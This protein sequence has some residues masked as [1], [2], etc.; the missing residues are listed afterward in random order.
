MAKKSTI[1]LNKEIQILPSTKF[2]DL[3]ENEIKRLKNRLDDCVL[4]LLY[5]NTNPIP[6]SLAHILTNTP[7]SLSNNDTSYTNGRVIKISYLHMYLPVKMVSFIILHEA[8]HVLFMHIVRG[9]LLHHKRFNYACDYWINH[10]LTLFMNNKS[11]NGDSIIEVPQYIRNGLPVSMLYDTKYSSTSLSEEQIYEM[12]KDDKKFNNID[13]GD[14]EFGGFDE[15]DYDID[16]DDYNKISGKIEQIKNHLKQ[17]GNGKGN[18]LC[19]IDRL[20]ANIKTTSSMWYKELDYIV[21]T[22]FNKQIRYD[23]QREHRR[24]KSEF[25]LPNRLTNKKNK[26]SLLVVFDTS[27]SISDDNLSLFVGE[28]SKFVDNTDIT[29][30]SVDTDVHNVVKCETT[31]DLKK[32]IPK[33]GGGTDFNPAFEFM[34][35]HN[36]DAIIYFTDGFGD[37]DVYK[38]IKL[39]NKVFW[40][41]ISSSYPDFIDGFGRAIV[42]EDDR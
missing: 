8:M 10:S 28:V 35:K 17:L 40:I 20:V 31:D 33:G 5:K 39:K 22:L 30:I 3:D 1:S 24:I 36:F 7:V 6:I 11:K 21:G 15:H 14:D 23:Y 26:P 16:E 12:L 38:Y 9:K 34:V 13:G 4:Y 42:I 27:G 18:A 19:E 2:K 37:L 25:F 41:L 32:Y 29:L